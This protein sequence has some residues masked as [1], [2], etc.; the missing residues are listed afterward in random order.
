MAKVNESG[1]LRKARAAMEAAKRDSVIRVDP[2][3][4]AEVVTFNDLADYLERHGLKVVRGEWPRGDERPT[5]YV[6]R[7]AG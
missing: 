5:V 4:G 7:A 3:T 6:V 2:A 1:R